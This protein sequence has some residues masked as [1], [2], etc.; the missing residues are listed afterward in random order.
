MSLLLRAAQR[1]RAVGTFGALPYDNPWVIPT[2]SAPAFT[3]AGVQ[4]TEDTAMQLLVVMACVRIIAGTVSGMPLNCVRTGPDGHQERMMPPPRIIADPFGGQNSLSGRFITRK[5]GI[6]QVMVSLLLRGN[7]FL[8]ATQLDRMN[9]PTGLQVLHPDVVGVDVSGDG[10]RKYTIRNVPVPAGRIVHITGLTQ[11]GY[12]LG[13]SV[14]GAAKRAISLGIAAEE[15]GARFFGSGAHLSGVIETEADM[16]PDKAKELAESFSASHAGLAN[17]HKV[18]V[19]TGGAKWA[20]ISVTPEDAQFLGTRAAQNLD[21][22]M[23]FGIPPH[24]LGQVDRTTS[25]GRGIEEQTLGFLKYTLKDWGDRIEDAFCAMTPTGWFARFDYDDLLRPDSTNRWATYQV[26]RNTGAMTV[27]EIRS[28][29][30]L[31]KLPGDLG[32][33]PFAPLNSAHA[34][35]PGWSPNGEVGGTE[36]PAPPVSP[37]NVSGAGAQAPKSPSA[38]SLQ[39]G[40]TPR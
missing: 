34:N 17:A 18:G 35:D 40:R 31:P 9:R 23:L 11:P 39:A 29:E 37:P 15:F 4:V 30:G 3:K 27:N 2:N 20:P 7:A 16:D 8:W 19:L 24:M 5:Q 10:T 36:P 22:A 33:D 38:K 12:P 26:A 32:D 14:I 25:W 28:R 13:I 6:S 1:T 21:L